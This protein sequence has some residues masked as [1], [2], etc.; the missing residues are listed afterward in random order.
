[1]QDFTVKELS[2]KEI[3]K[4]DKPK[5][6]PKFGTSDQ[7]TR[8]RRMRYLNKTIIAIEEIWLDF[9]EGV[10]KKILVNHLLV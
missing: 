4:M 5:N 6:L 10:V 8:M 3:K 2:R 1:M 9:D 7:G